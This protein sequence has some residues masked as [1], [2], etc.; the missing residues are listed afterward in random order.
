MSS[1]F[2]IGHGNKDLK[3]FIEELKTYHI[4]YLID[5]RTKPY[6][7]WNPQ[8]NQNSLKKSLEEED[9]VYAFFGDSLGGLP[10]D[11]SCYNSDNKID[12]DLVKGKDFFK[13]SAERLIVANERNVR[14]A[15][16]CSESKPGECHRSKLIGQY[17]SEN[18]NI[19]INHIISK[20]V[21]KPQEI[22][23]LELN[24]GKSLVNLFGEQESFT[25]RNSYE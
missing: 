15:I 6:S 21:I 22:V 1:L 14:L 9:I 3:V 5:V 13:E 23:M 24:K 20:S 17:L 8:Y 4:S 7:K 25:S 2:S 18:N 16:M 11:K 12:Y 10:S 19:S